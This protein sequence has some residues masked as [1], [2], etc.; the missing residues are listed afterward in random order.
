MLN[1]EL[2]CG[3]YNWFTLHLTY[4]SSLSSK[5]SHFTVCTFSK[6]VPSGAINMEWIAAK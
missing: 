2:M 6:F 5:F 4:S 1:E 3:R